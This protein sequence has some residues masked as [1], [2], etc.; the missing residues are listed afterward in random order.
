[1]KKY[2]LILMAA[3]LVVGCEKETSVTNPPADSNTTIVN[4][5]P[6]AKTEKTETNTTVTTPDKEKKTE[7][8]TKT[9]SSP[10]P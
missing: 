6:A 10:N 5:S 4:P 8:E 2:I 1:M 3:G 9:T 7:T